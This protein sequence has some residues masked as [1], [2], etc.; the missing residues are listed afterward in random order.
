MRVII[1]RLAFVKSAIAIG[2][3]WKARD[4]F[5]QLANTCSAQ[6]CAFTAHHL[7]SS[8]SCIL[9]KLIA[10]HLETTRGSRQ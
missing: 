6:S 8:V 10:S 9:A 5:D 7:L 3:P 2:A 1:L 4:K